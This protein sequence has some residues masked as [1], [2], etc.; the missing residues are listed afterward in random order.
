[1]VAVR[2]ADEAHA[3]FRGTFKRFIQCELGRLEAEPSARVDQARRALFVHDPRNRVAAR[4]AAL[5]MVAISRHSHNAVR[6]QS[7]RIGGDEIF[8]RDA[9][10]VLCGAVRAQCSRCDRR[11]FIN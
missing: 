6:A 7:L 3:V 11:Q 9:R 5:Q 8:R 2:H 4:T 10:G 1:M